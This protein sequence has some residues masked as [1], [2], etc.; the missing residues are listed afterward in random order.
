MTKLTITTLGLLFFSSLALSQTITGKEMINKVNCSDY[1][2]FNEFITQKG[3]SEKKIDPQREEIKFYY[4]YRSD[5]TFAATS[6]S[7]VTGKRNDVFFSN[8]SGDLFR[9]SFRTVVKAQYQNLLGELTD[10][11]FKSTKTTDKG[12]GKIETEYKSDS[13]TNLIVNV[14]TS[15]EVRKSDNESYIFYN[16]EMWR[17]Q[18]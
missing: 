16:I 4:C 1:S 13:Y 12:D 3:F 15:T 7:K 2:C 6:N 11:K 10:L 8:H 17:K 9:F 18:N 14:T 5:S